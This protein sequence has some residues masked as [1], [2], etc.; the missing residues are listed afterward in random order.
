MLSFPYK[1]SL[2]CRAG[3]SDWA[4][5]LNAS[6]SGSLG[7]GGGGGDNG[8]GDAS[9][10]VYISPDI[11]TD[12]DPT[13]ACQPPCTFVFPPWTLSSTTTISQPPVTMTVEDMWPLVETLDGGVTSTVYASTLTTTTITVPPLI[14]DTISLWNFEWTD[15]QDD[16]IY[17]TSSVIFP[18]LTLTEG[19]DVLTTTLPPTTS[20]GS[21]VETTTTLVGATY[22]F[23]D[24]VYPPVMS[25]TTGQLT[26]SSGTQPSPT[27]GH[28]T[29]SNLPPPPPPPGKLG[30]VHVTVGPPK[31]TCSPGEIGCGKL[32]VLDCLPKPPCI[33]ICGCIGIGC[34]NGGGCLGSGCSGGGGDNNEPEPSSCETSMTATDCEVA[35]SLTVASGMSEYTTNCYTTACSSTVAC[36]AVGTTTTSET[37]VGCPTIPPYT[38]W[39]TDENEPV[40]T[41]GDGGYG[42]TLVA[43]GTWTPPQGSVTPP[44]TSPSSPSPTVPPSTSFISC[45]YYGQDPDQ[46]RTADFCSCSGLTYPPNEN[47]NVNPPNSCAYTALPQDTTSVATNTIITT[48]ADSCQACTFEGQNE[49]CTSVPN[50]TPVPPSTTASQ[51]PPTAAPSGT[52]LLFSDDNVSVNG[53]LSSKIVCEH[54]LTCASQCQNNYA[55]YTIHD[56]FN[57]CV[58]LS[59]KA[60]SFLVGYIEFCD[61]ESN[62]S[63]QTFELL[64]DSCEGGDI[65]A[66]GCGKEK[67]C[68]QPMSP[69]SYLNSYQAENSN[70]DS[71]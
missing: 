56:A 66:S 57:K 13:V 48:Y 5:D 14:T 38:P 70:N 24:G 23:S 28:S 65:V 49:Q 60:K 10:V 9:G 36:D 15:T 20:G 45:D 62:C 54:L 52:I 7:L 41:M 29:T 16:T 51:P 18:P 35:C 68:R 42:G 12:P 44:P 31:P 6:Y 2:M 8:T 40:P 61:C 59:Q 30:S 55:N 25:P 33:G 26:S 17:L 11:F 27:G 58:K 50:C 22:T 71:G 3:T 63:Y 67:Y 43:T 34:P 19:S 53:Q 39:Y 69:A 4:M 21:S 1:W 32:C 64:G 46:G 37:T 47:T